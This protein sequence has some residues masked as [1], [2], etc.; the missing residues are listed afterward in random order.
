MR[1]SL[2]VLAIALFAAA[3]C[4]DDI[5]DPAAQPRNLAPLYMAQREGVPD[6]YIVILKRPAP[7]A[8][9]TAAIA[10]VAAAARVAPD[11]QYHG[12]SRGFAARL[13]AAQLSTLRRDAR[14]DWI[15][16]D[17]V[18]RLEATQYMDV[19]GEP[20]GLDRIDQ[21]T[22]PLSGSYFYSVQGNGVT[23][24]V[25]DTGI[26]ANHSQ[27][28]V[29][30]S[31]TRAANI[32]DAFG[33]TGDDCNGHGTHVAGTIGGK[34]YGVAKG[35][36]LR[37]LRALDCA[38]NGTSSTVLAAMDLVL[39]TFT[40]P[41]VVNM[42]LGGGHS[43]AVNLWID[44]LAAAGAFPVVSAGNDNANACEGSPSGAIDAF[45]VA[46]TDITDTPATFSNWGRCVDIYAPGVAIISSYIGSTTA[47][48]SASGTSMAAPHVAGVAAI[49]K[50][51]FG[52]LS[53][54]A[55]ISRLM[56][57][58]SAGVVVDNDAGAIRYGTPN[59][60]VGKKLW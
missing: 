41:A 60:I 38:G 29:S 45:T 26:K 48:A 15:E 20:W 31:V 32:F 42:S 57:G 5:T 12:A 35:V 7:G 8:F 53:N 4:T 19:G 28:K 49:I 40:A 50:K 18:I 24:Y 17:Q 23:V 46:A 9:S 2:S 55:M 37:G 34:T 3:S 58:A 11:I 10:D 44:M 1:R 56:S 54:A 51:K 52:D 25:I 43:K 33:G 22:L 39:T 13:D 21:A 14:V 16:Q 59:R 6:R 47:L 27:F 30:S 36:Q